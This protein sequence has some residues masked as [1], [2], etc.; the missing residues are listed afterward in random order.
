MRTRQLAQFPSDPVSSQV[1][2]QEKVRTVL[3]ERTIKGQN[4]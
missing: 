2:T 1:T 3:D 4:N